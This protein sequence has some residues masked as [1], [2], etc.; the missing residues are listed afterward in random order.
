MTER[1]DIT[2]S[3]NETWQPTI[4]YAYSGDP[5]PTLGASARMQWR[6]YEGQVGD[7]LIDLAAV[8]MED[9]LATL[10]DIA[11]GCAR[12]GDRILRFSPALS[13]ATLAGLPTGL[14]QPEPGEADQYTWDIVIT[15][16][17]ATRWR[18]LAG[19]VL[20]SKGTVN[21]A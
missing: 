7:P 8:P 10:E 15:F 3:R 13:P 11:N 19:V 21:A 5:I 1:L 9:I 12:P 2:A 6:L 18:V 20:L 14:N 17:D 16:S 4:D